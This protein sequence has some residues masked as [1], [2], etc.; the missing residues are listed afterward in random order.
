MWYRG[1][2]LIKGAG[3]FA[4]VLSFVSNEL[5]SDN[6]ESNFQ[7]GSGSTEIPSILW[8]QRSSNL[9]AP[10]NAYKPQQLEENIGKTNNKSWERERERERELKLRMNKNEEN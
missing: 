2:A 9:T 1:L 10:L 6:R 7:S 5:S 4:K 8:W 3:T